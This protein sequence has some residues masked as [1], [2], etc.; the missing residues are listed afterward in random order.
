MGIIN[1]PNNSLPILKSLAWPPLGGLF[2]NILN[3]ILS[4][5]TRCSNV[6]MTINKASLPTKLSIRAACLT[7]YIMTHN[8]AP[9]SLI[10]ISL[11]EEH[12]VVFVNQTNACTTSNL[13]LLPSV[14]N[15]IAKITSHYLNMSLRECCTAIL[16]GYESIPSKQ[17]ST[18]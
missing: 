9:K 18:G 5:T 6:L 16:S 11:N 14:T 13:L 2:A 15:T 10:K 4:N 7:T 17:R 3:R 12:T 8:T 1:S